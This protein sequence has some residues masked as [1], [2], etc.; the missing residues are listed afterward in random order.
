MVGFGSV[1]N[2]DTLQLNYEENYDKKLHRVFS[3]IVQYDM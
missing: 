2:Y 1:Q 3:G